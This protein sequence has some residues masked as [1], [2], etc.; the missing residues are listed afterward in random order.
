MRVTSRRGSAAIV[1][2]LTT[3]LSVAHGER[4]RAALLPDKLDGALRSLLERPVAGLSKM[5][6]IVSAQPGQ[7][8]GLL[9]SLRL[10]G[11]AVVNEHQMIDAAT[12]DLPS[13][14]VATLSA[15]D[16][17]GHG[18]HVASLIGGSATPSSGLYAGVAPGVRL[19][20]LKVLD[21]TGA[22]S[23]SAVI[24][25]IEFA[26][27]NKA[28]LGIQI[29]NFPLGH[30]I[31]ERAARDRLVRIA[32]AAVRRGIVVVVSAGNQG[33]DSTT[34]EVAYS[35]VSSPGNAD[36]VLS[37]DMVFFNAPAFGDQA[38]WESHV[39]WGDHVVWGDSTV[40]N[41]DRSWGSHVV[42][43]DSTVGRTEGEHVV[44]GDTTFGADDV[45]WGNLYTSDAK[46]AD[47]LRSS[48][49]P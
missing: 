48:S 43:G 32:S 35:G 46:P 16:D 18:T 37:G 14:L 2:T 45:A 19:I 12:G 7:L 47:T 8:S 44:W 1:V 24:S 20:G 3:I 26:T 38:A 29:I 11:F 39:M 13:L 5:R 23:T 49:Q 25:A 9:L 31:D 42:C 33:L 22:G 30:P 40:W 15:F 36:R 34:G 10:G 4:P 17:F 6:V 27:K 28:A 21:G 41:A